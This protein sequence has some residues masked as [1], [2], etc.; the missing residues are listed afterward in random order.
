MV[1]SE[2]EA[3]EQMMVWRNKSLVQIRAELVR[4]T[5]KHQ[6]LC[7]EAA[8]RLEELL[9]ALKAIVAISE[10]QEKERK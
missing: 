6:M 8:D 3:Y 5:G 2:H 10:K 4:V 9:L 7:N 1:A